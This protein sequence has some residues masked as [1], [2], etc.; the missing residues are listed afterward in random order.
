M[1]ANDD[2]TYEFAWLPV[3]TLDKGWVWL[4][5]VVGFEQF[6]GGRYVKWYISKP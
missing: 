4:R 3:Y 6:V 1:T 2:I 5:W